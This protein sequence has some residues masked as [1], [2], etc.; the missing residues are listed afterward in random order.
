MNA[1]RARATVIYNDKDITRSLRE[2][3]SQITFTDHADGESDTVSI[4]ISDPEGKW[5]D[6]W[7]PEKKDSIDVTINVS[8]W[9][10]DG[11][12]RKLRCGAFSVDQVSASGDSSSSVTLS[13]GAISGPVQNGFRETARSKTWKKTTL[14]QIGKRI[15]QRYGMKLEYDADTIRIKS[16]EQSETSDSAFLSELCST[17]GLLM[18]A[19]RKKMVI[20]D[21]E[22][23]KKRAPV[24]TINLRYDVQNWSYADTLTRVYTGGELTYT[25]PSSGKEIKKKIGSGTNILKISDSA[26]SAA[27][28]ERKLRARVNGENH[29]KTQLSIS[30]MG[31]VCIV[32]GVVI[33]VTGKGSKVDG[34]YFVDTVTHSVSASGGYTVDLS[35]S[36]IREGL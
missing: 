16:Q 11:D 26:D 25:D 8:D 30:M 24:K 14:E 2:Y 36:K 3:M 18:K 5:I 21:R 22:T 10:K 4:D 29:G 28:A 35:C 13:I 33:K 23:Y 32:A 9:E 1:R 20:Y 19:Y 15:A 27:D 34:S 31:D 17:Y 6:A 12:S 7:M